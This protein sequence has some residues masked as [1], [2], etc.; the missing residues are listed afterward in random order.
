M[1]T[2]GTLGISQTITLATTVTQITGSGQAKTITLWESDVDVYVVTSKSVADGGAL[3][4][5]GRRPVA[6]ASMPIDIDISGAG[7]LGL[8][9]A[10]AGDLHFELSP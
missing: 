9:G 5:S 1:A 10:S 2:A 4:S 8:A 3:P 6:A 7:F